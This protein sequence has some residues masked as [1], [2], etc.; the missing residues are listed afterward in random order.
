MW[1]YIGRCVL[2]RRRLEGREEGRE[3]GGK[4][5]T[6]LEWWIGLGGGWFEGDSVAAMYACDSFS[7]MFRILFDKSPYPEEG[8][9]LIRGK[10]QTL[11][12]SM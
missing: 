11:C 2:E 12:V 6:G 4:V 1:G 8:I 9:S 5:S 10:N 3:G 7:S